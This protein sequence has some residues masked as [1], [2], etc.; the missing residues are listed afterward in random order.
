VGHLTVTGT[1]TPQKKPLGEHVTLLTKVQL[2]RGR[3]LAQENWCRPSDATCRL[4]RAAVT[5]WPLGSGHLTHG[6]PRVTS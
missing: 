5:K 4:T 2:M 3:V 6:P 1:V